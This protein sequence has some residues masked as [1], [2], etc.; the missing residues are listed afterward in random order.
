MA[1]TTRMTLGAQLETIP[2]YDFDLNPCEFYA[3]DYALEDYEYLDLEDIFWR[4]ESPSRVKTYSEEE[5]CGSHRISRSSWRA[6]QRSCHAMPQAQAG[7]TLEDALNAGIITRDI[8]REGLFSFKC[9][10]C[11]V[12]MTGS[13]CAVAHIN[14]RSHTKVLTRQL[15]LK[16]F[17]QADKAR[18]S[19]V[20]TSVTRTS[21]A[22]SV[23]VNVSPRRVPVVN[24][25]RPMVVEPRDASEFRHCKR[26]GCLY[27]YVRG[28]CSCENREAEE[29]KHLEKHIYWNN[30][31]C[32]NKCSQGPS[33][34]VDDTP[35]CKKC[36]Y[37]RVCVCNCPS[38]LIRSILYCCEKKCILLTGVKAKCG[39]CVSLGCCRCECVTF[40][41][42]MK[43]YSSSHAVPMPTAQM[44]MLDDISAVPGSINKALG[45]VHELLDLVK[46]KIDAFAKW[47][48]LPNL[49]IVALTVN[50]ASLIWNIH[51]R[52]WVNA[53]I[54]GFLIC[55]ALNTKA[56]LIS[57]ALELVR[58][59][60]SAWSTAVTNPVANDPQSAVF[61]GPEG[62]VPQSGASFDWFGASC[63][64]IL[65]TL[66]R[67]YTPSYDSLSKILTD[68]GR[69]SIG[70]RS[71]K[72]LFN[73]LYDFARKLYYTH[74]LGIDVAAQDLEKA[75]PGMS[76]ALKL[77]DLLESARFKTV[78]LDRSKKLCQVVIALGETMEKC[79]IL[80]IQAKDTSLVNI[81]T[82]KILKLNHVVKLA[83]NSAA[84]ARS[85]KTAPTS[86]Y[87]Y[88]AAGVGKSV[89][90]RALITFIRHK[91]YANTSWKSGDISFVRAPGS[92]Y[93]DGY[94]GQP[95]LVYDDIFQ[96][97]DSTSAPCPDFMDIISVVNESPFHLNMAAAEDK[98]NVYMECDFVLATSNVKVVNP[99]SIMSKDAIHRR[100]DICVEVSVKPEYCTPF[101]PKLDKDKLKTYTS[102]MNI[103]GFTGEPYQFQYYSMLDGT[104]IGNT[105]GLSEFLE[106]LVEV[107]VKKRQESLDLV[108]SLE[109]TFGGS[110]ETDATGYTDFLKDVGV[111]EFYDCMV[112][113]A[114]TLLPSAPPA[115]MPHAQGNYTTRVQNSDHVVLNLSDALIA[116]LAECEIEPVASGSSTYADYTPPSESKLAEL[117]TWFLTDIAKPVDTFMTSLYKRFTA[118]A[119]KYMSLTSIQAF[120]GRVWEF[121]S[122]PCETLFGIPNGIVIAAVSAIVFKGVTYCYGG[123]CKLM[124][125]NSFES[126]RNYDGSCRCGNCSKYYDP[127]KVKHALGSDEH[128]LGLLR[129]L[130]QHVETAEKTTFAMLYT[131][132]AK[133]VFETRN[134]NLRCE[135]AAY[136][137]DVKKTRVGYTAESSPYSH[138][139]RRPKTGYAA[140]VMEGD[141]MTPYVP[142]YELASKCLI[143][144]Y[145]NK[146]P[147]AQ[148]SDF[149]MLEQHESIVKTNM[150]RLVADTTFSLNG[151]FVTGRTLLIPGHFWD[152]VVDTFQIQNP[153]SRL[154]QSVRKRDCVH[155]QC[156][157]VDGTVI[158]V[159]LVECPRMIASR[160]NIVNMFAVANSFAR[161][162][163][164]TVVISGLR[165]VS[166]QTVLNSIH[167]GRAKPT[168]RKVE[169]SG[170][171]KV[172][173]VN[174]GFWY[175]V[176]TAPGD[177]GAILLARNK[178]MLGKLI[179][180]HVA[181]WNGE[182][183]A[184]ALS[185]ELILR[186]L[187][188]IH[189]SSSLV[190][191]KVPFAPKLQP[192]MGKVL[193][194]L[195]LP[196][197]KYM[198]DIP[199]LAGDYIPLGKLPSPHR[200]TK[201][202]IVPSLIAGMVAAPLMMPAFLTPK[203]VNGEVKDPMSIGIQKVLNTQAVLPTE[204]TDAAVSDVRKIHMAGKGLKRV[205]TYEEALKGI[206]GEKNLAPLN[207]TS[208][209][210]YPYCLDNKGPGKR[211]WFGN[212]EWIINTEIEKDVD[213][214]IANAKANRRSD[215]VYVATLKDERRPVAKVMAGKTR[216][217]AAAPMH[218]V[219]AV[220]KYFLGFVGSVMDGC[221][222]N[223]IGVGTNVYSLDWH[224]TASA[225]QKFGPAVI[226]GDFSNFDGS[227]HQG[228]LWEILDMINDWYDDG[229]ENALVRRVL[230]EDICNARLL[231]NGEIVHTTHSQPSG[232]PMTVILN[233]I[234]NQIV[235]R[236]A[237]LDLKVA[238]GASLLND[239]REHVSMQTYGDDNCLNID[240]ET[241]EWYNQSTITESLAKFGLTYTDEAK[242]GEVV[243]TR[244]LSD[245]AYLKRRFVMDG[246]GIY[247]GPLDFDVVMEMCNWIKGNTPV[248][249]T[250][251][252]VE[253]AL[254]ELGLHGKEKYEEYSQKLE[255]ACHEM[256]VYPTVPSW[257]EIDD[258]HHSMRYGHSRFA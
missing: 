252:N 165:S 10:V 103:K 148:M 219:I 51:E 48:N 151:L 55:R 43:G 160:R 110:V 134:L 196:H 210:G 44:G 243:E 108:D 114:N 194:E 241:K 99:V 26:C 155:H 122:S 164:G 237:Y 41:K 60:A 217:F 106:D 191:A 131:S 9:T 199:T 32:E 136:S 100:F 213:Q 121:V 97:K 228:I 4:R 77:C 124:G 7:A 57:D 89:L 107:H 169:Y 200:P 245:I 5:Y 145:H 230:F 128:G 132:N 203:T 109:S 156:T 87:L 143:P 144:R 111:E 218:Y 45:S 207:R 233:S 75:Y 174:S 86:V 240:A 185:H 242:S 215:V 129:Y 3:R 18:S 88:G 22:C 258:V 56:D 257:L 47:I 39:K 19:A 141:K 83:R 94:V 68:F 37:P 212:D 126:A 234:F 175:D 201:S 214:V 239:F 78:Y 96:V 62:P 46:N 231:V 27:N 224:K 123:G 40:K 117:K 186:N 248:A 178:T 23:S 238:R 216:V 138:D 15:L 183:L 221:I 115:D 91:Y 82:A 229:E 211:H 171:S 76:E 142:A 226:A 74:I 73:W 198:D 31:C 21:N 167:T 28:A 20:E 6:K 173:T 54:S 79:R 135:N 176:D 184:V 168:T 49:D 187:D 222:D 163:E 159:A 206:E 190:D 140:E 249:A 195:S 33:N 220:R 118:T 172:Y 127:K 101:N 236:M 254:F 29:R 113:R 251:L 246:Q 192:E 105:F 235:M 157:A 119:A 63:V 197:G 250:Q 58:N 161:I 154:T 182:G 125:I 116:E 166:G 209:P 36:N 253:T 93:W 150:V 16:Q 247:T 120:F 137:H 162:H 158:D 133:K 92:K 1:T 188:R 244:K 71:L 14:G 69:S 177:C 189:N 255:K 65:A 59:Y 38:F 146:K 25:G 67:G 11:D 85:A 70:F 147:V 102:R 53:G 139:V 225:L 35:P 42:L 2:E 193:P 98:K 179:G 208:S 256:D 104:P 30:Y 61:P 202:T 152:S 90:V 64:A 170:S 95:I 34:P 153:F 17:E 130:A 84:F 24:L 223:E 80:A 66:A 227:L 13:E 149:S 181:G 81:L 8:T 204:I 52:E 205:L 12:S 50:T 72:E 180:I 232:N 112:E